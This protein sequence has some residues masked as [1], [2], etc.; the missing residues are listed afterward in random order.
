MSPVRT[1]RLA[2]LSRRNRSSLIAQTRLCAKETMWVR[3]MC[4]K[5]CAYACNKGGSAKLREACRV[6]F[7][8]A[9]LWT[10]D[11]RMVVWY[12]DR[13]ARRDLLSSESWAHLRVCGPVWCATR[14]DTSLFVSLKHNINTQNIYTPTSRTV[15]WC[16]GAM[17]T[18]QRLSRTN[19]K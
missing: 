7:E 18:G 6:C 19:L 2:Q 15:S 17:E 11:V 10:E 5:W 14:L 1:G 3:R 16:H 8:C 12:H 9:L 13:M 4:C